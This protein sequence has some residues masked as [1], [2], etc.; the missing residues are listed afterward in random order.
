MNL[1]QVQDD[2]QSLPNDNRTMQALMAYAN[3][4]NPQVPPYLALGELNRRKQLMERSQQAQQ[5][6]QAQQNPQGTVKDQ[7]EQS[8]GVMALQQQRNR[9]TME[10]LF[11]GR[12][13]QPGMTPRGIEQSAPI[14]GQ[15]G[16]NLAQLMS[17]P[18]AQYRSG[19]IVALSG[20]TE[21]TV[22]DEEDQTEKLRKAIE[23]SDALAAFRNDPR[24]QSLGPNERAL[25]EADIAKGNAAPS[26]ASSFI[27]DEAAVR[28]R[29]LEEEAA[30]RRAAAPKREDYDAERRREEFL[31][32]NPQLAAAINRDVEG[33]SFKRLEEYQTA[34]RA[35][36][37]K[38]R[39]ENARTRPGILQLLGQAAGTTGGM[40]RGDAIAR[41][42]GG[43]AGLSSKQE[44]SDVEQE[45]G[46]RL[47]ELQLQQLR[48]SAQ[49]KLE[50]AQRARAEGRMTDAAKL[51]D[52]FR[53][54]TAAHD[55]AAMSLLR[56]EI[57]ATESAASR[58]DTQQAITQRARETLAT[59]ER[60]ADRANEN[61][62]L[63]QEMILARPKGGTSNAG[64]I[65]ALRKIID[66]QIKLEE[67]VLDPRNID[68]TDA[69]KKAAQESLVIL[70]QQ[71]KELGEKQGLAASP[72]P[73]EGATT[74]P[75]AN[76][77]KEGVNTTFQNGQTWTLK[78]GKPTRV[79]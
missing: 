33:E 30:R 42:L 62:I 31:K 55:T 28:R 23:G 40:S 19:G 16:N 1:I 77:L 66:S 79:N 6:Q 10:Q 7:I 29:K 69:D 13:A 51:M 50:E 45:R 39:A 3:G 67:K 36:L 14:Q 34:M 8:A 64:E 70:R 44:A 75:P 46:L 38:Q 12:G 63:V 26:F 56:G 54:D 49:E 22:G 78:N 48:M 25:I 58:A 72:K 18:A 65:N 32:A 73:A 27:I 76:M 59:R 20:G 2:L 71:L 21:G 9:E 74:T 60:I 52:Q 5:A 43:Y 4:A 57:S 11:R 61:R 35:E 47:K 37:D 68:A 24:Y 15:V 41:M 17:Y 53:K